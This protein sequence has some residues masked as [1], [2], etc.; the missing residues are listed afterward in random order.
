MTSPDVVDLEGAEELLDRLRSVRHQE[1]TE[2]PRPLEALCAELAELPLRPG[3]VV[4]VA[5]SNGLPL[6]R[7]F[8]AC[9]L[10]GYVP[11]LMAPSTPAPRVGETAAR[12]GAAAV[13]GSRAKAG[14][15]QPA[16][17]RIEGVNVVLRTGHPL[18]LHRPGQA[19]LLTSGTSGMAT[20]CLHEIPAL[21]RNAR[22]HADSV[23]LTAEDR[24]LI[25]L[26][27]YYSFALV[28]QLLGCYVTGATPVVSGPPFNAAE[29][30]DVIGREGITHSSLTPTLVSAL[31]ESGCAL[32]DGLRTLTVGGQGLAPERTGE[33]LS[34]HP[35]LGVYLT[36][37]LT[38]AGPRV[39][40]L[41]AHREPPHRH[42]SVGL[43]MDGVRISL[44]DVGRGPGEQEVLV[45]SD[46]VFVRRVGT[47][48]ARAAH[49]LLD[50]SVLATGDLGRVDEDGY[51]YLTG[52]LSDFVEVRGEKVSLASLR[53]VATS[54]PEVVAATAA[55]HA[56]EDLLAL[57]LHVR[58]T[59]EDIDEAGLRRRLFS[60]LSPH[61]R[62]GRLTFHQA[63]EDALRK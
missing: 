3:S 55:Y 38:Q 4:L 5:L 14:P 36:Y 62:P 48:H 25:T 39:S 49:E 30:V 31:L 34:R 20:G 41:A 1:S 52:R 50:G 10:T 40:T 37:G 23:G 27:M 8:F 47:P 16:A 6:L 32:P 35:G 58:G 61:E 21:L 2:P 28:A 33:L 60:L 19:I 18:Q 42:G 56:D 15:G 9:Q 45:H 26:P 24:V 22:R 57:G 12:L 13:V 29:Y 54:L 53:S 59:S 43:P 51:L 11:V 46:T 44:R 7:F 63:D 17:L